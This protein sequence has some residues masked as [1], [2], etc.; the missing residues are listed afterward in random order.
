MISALLI[1]TVS[2]FYLYYSSGEDKQ[3][4]ITEKISLEE[5]VG[6]DEEGGVITPAAKQF[7]VKKAQKQ[8]KIH[9]TTTMKLY[10]K[11]DS[12]AFIA[13]IEKNIE[14]SRYESEDTYDLSF[15]IE[16]E[17]LERM[18]EFQEKE[19]EILAAHQNMILAFNDS[20]KENQEDDSYEMDNDAIDN[21]EDDIASYDVNY[22][23]Q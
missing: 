20:L 16:D 6:S 7:T 15:E 4:P 9:Q 19:Q 12:D 2:M 3:Q 13:R 22:D 17:M 5:S 1:S 11:E 21:Y 18:E 8:R 10:E 23:Y 14:E